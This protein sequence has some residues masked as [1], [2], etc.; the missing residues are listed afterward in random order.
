MKKMKTLSI[1]ALIVSVLPVATLIPVF[2][3]ITLSDGVRSVWAGA[4]ILFILVGIF[5]SVI[6]VRNKVNRS[7]LN[8]ISTAISAMWL[9]LMIGIVILALLINFLW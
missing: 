6:C 9:L 7:I 2:L 3:K 4:N 8:I 5:L 1:V